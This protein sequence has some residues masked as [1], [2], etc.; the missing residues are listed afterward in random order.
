MSLLSCAEITVCMLMPHKK[1]SDSNNIPKKT[2][3]LTDKMFC[4]VLFCFLRVALLLVRL[5]NCSHALLC[6]EKA[7]SLIPQ[8]Y[9][10]NDIVELGSRF[11]VK[12]KRLSRIEQEY[13]YIFFHLT[14]SEGGFLLSSL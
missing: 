4:S 12:I 1:G 9:F 3:R 8:N 2:D 6:K 13:I 14:V 10:I 7:F 11:S 5:L